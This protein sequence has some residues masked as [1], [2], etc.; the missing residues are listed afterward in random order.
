MDFRQEFLT[1]LKNGTD[2]D[3]LLDLVSRYQ[4][5]GLM[6]QQAYQLLHELWLEF[7]FAQR[8][9]DSRIQDDLEYVMEKVWYECPAQGS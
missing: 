3:S 9:G 2:A 8:D 6:P 7:G 4:A 5:Q 1:A